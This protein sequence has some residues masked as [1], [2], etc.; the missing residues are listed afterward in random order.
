MEVLRELESLTGKPP[1]ELFDY[2]IG[3]ST[4]AVVVAMLAAFR[5]SA[6][7]SL[8]YYKR[9]CTKL[10]ARDSLGGARRLLLSHGY[11]DTAA[12]ENELR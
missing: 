3:V 5:L 10:F 7:E 6:D 12:W 4:G 2:F 11:Y 1:C 9:A 8:E